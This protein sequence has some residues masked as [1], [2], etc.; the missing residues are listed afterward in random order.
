[1]RGLSDFV[2]KGLIM[3]SD[4]HSVHSEAAKMGNR[5]FQKR[6]RHCK[7]V[8]TLGP[9]SSDEKSIRA[10][11]EAGLDVA[12]LNF[13]HGTHETHL[14]NIEMIRR[15]SRE[16]GRQVAILQDLQGPKIRCGKLLNDR[17]ELKKGERY[18]LA[19]GIEQTH[20]DTIPIDYR[21]LVRDVKDGQ[22]VLM[23][24]GLLIF[25]IEK[26]I[27]QL[28]V[29]VVR[30]G[31]ILKNRK[32]VNFPDSK[33]S[34][35]SMTEKDSRDLLF[36]IAHHV[37]YIAL[38][39]VQDP[40]DVEQLR[41]MI[42]AL[43]AEIPIVAKIEKLQA[44]DAIDAITKVSDALMVAR[45]DLGVEG[46]V[47]RVPSLQRRIVDCAARHGKPVIIATQMLE[48]MIENPRASAAEIAD[49]ANG[50]LEGAD[51]TMLS[52]EVASG[53]YPVDCVKKMANIIEEVEAWTFQ[54]P[55][56]FLPANDK[57]QWEDHEAIARAACEAADALSA[58]AIVCLT[59]TGSIARTMSQW[60]PRTPIIAISPRRD[61]VQ[62]LTL[63]W[64]V[65]ALPNPLFY[66]TDVLLH[67]LPKV[68]KELNLVQS[69]DFVVITAGIP[70]N[71]MRSTNMMKINRIP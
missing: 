43:G 24:D 31:G 49:V 19:F 59:L 63:L 40:K 2:D 54:K 70:I 22:R 47:E 35:P 48:S 25:Q 16:A 3:V 46:D 17:L 41:S 60:R 42:R 33:L 58:K 62:R 51:C 57:R 23:D 8:G 44:V 38:S 28:V 66:N 1:M 4:T 20:A 12:R 52:G 7:I 15:I 45:G 10:L 5:I 67:D 30:E 21:D 61:V 65:Y 14:K 69:G 29:V 11:I 56:R 68:L 32:G 18:T 64:G 13:S 9:V 55:V 71:Q 34:L 37:D 50:V 27:G 26:I 6:T 36:G 39:F 53:K